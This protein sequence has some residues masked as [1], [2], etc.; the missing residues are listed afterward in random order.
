[1]GPGGLQRGR[2]HFGRRHGPAGRPLR[3]TKLRTRG[4]ALIGASIRAD[5]FALSLVIAPPRAG[6]TQLPGDHFGM[7]L[8]LAL[9]GHQ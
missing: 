9:A 8:L 5:R 1:M 4:M 7:T 2:G 3:A 6:R